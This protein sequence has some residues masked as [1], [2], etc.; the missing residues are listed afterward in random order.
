MAGRVSE[1]PFP[2][3]FYALFAHRFGGVMTLE[4]DGR[5]W[6]VFWKDGL[7]VDAESAS[8][9][10]SLPRAMVAEGLLE[11][12]QVGDLLRRMALEPTR[13]AS[14]IFAAMK[15]LDPGSAIKAARAALVVRSRRV[16]GLPEAEYRCEDVAHERLDGGPVDPRWLMHRGLRLHYDAARLG[17]DLAP[18]EQ[19]AIKLNAGHEETLAAFAF[20]DEERFVMAYLAKGYWSLPD[21]VEACLGLPP[22]II[23]SLVYSLLAC[24]L[25]DVKPATSVPRLRKRAREET[26]NVG[27]AAAAALGKAQAAKA[28][29][30]PAP[31][32]SLPPPEAAAIREQILAKVALIDAG[33][34]HFQVLELPRNAP[35]SEAKLA[36]FKLAKVFHPDRVSAMKLHDLQPVVEK[37]FGRITT[38]F[39]VLT[40]EAKRAEYIKVL[41]A[42]GEDAVKRREAE[43]EA[44]ALKILEAED[45]FN[46]GE[47][48]LRR[49]NFAQA[50]ELFKKAIEGNPDEAEHHAY[51][52]WAQ[53]QASPNKDATLA[54]AKQ[55]L[56]KSL[57]INPQCAPAYYFL[58]HVYNHAQDY[59]RSIA[60]FQRALELRPG[61]T[62]AER[63]L[64]V[65][66]MRRQK[67]AL[68][69]PGKASASLNPFRK[70]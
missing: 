37:T 9:E 50:Q 64:R 14:E 19:Y 34:D 68:S 1:R 21:L 33:A 58:G 39:N 67:G 51:F 32:P 26:L 20:G 48:A 4:Q 16:F 38:A 15:G 23:H 69:G 61:W 54:Q 65:L 44:K 47:M 49:G 66:E 27:P 11:P 45:L 18:L 3:V 22:N 2:K 41:A 6:K 36:Y 5:S 30:R 31:S 24:E 28:P 7:I 43:N 10:D 12:G 53:W 57:E 25:L 13:K 62:E 55:V 60:Q 8:P 29:A 42:G 17:K 46:Q 56:A 35:A 70:K 52:A 63:E 40:D 59:G